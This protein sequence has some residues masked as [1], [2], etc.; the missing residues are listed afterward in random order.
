MSHLHA[1][2]P[3]PTRDQDPVAAFLQLLSSEREAARR[4]DLDLLES[5]QREKQQ[6]MPM[7]VSCS[8][9]EAARR[10]LRREAQHNITLMRYLATCLEGLVVGDVPHEQVYDA[11]GRCGAP[12][13]YSIRG[14]L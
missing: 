4:A 14:R 2:A 8:P 10:K 13:A 11:R 6:L 5:L 12:A 3:E 9:S 1:S 7:L